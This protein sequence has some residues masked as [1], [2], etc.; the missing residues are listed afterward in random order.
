MATVQ[1]CLIKLDVM[2]PF[3]LS[4]LNYLHIF[5]SCCAKELYSTGEQESHSVEDGSISAPQSAAICS[6]FIRMQLI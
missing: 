2:L 5:L 4:E 3:A 6:L 1:K